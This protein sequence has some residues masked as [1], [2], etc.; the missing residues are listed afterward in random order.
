M[1]RRVAHSVFLFL[2]VIPCSWAVIILKDDPRRA[3]VLLI[4]GCIGLAINGLSLAS[5]A[6]GLRWPLRIIAGGVGLIVLAGVM[7]MWQWIRTQL[8]PETPPAALARREILQSQMINLLWI[9][10]VVVYVLLTIAIQP[11]PPAKKRP[12]KPRR[13]DFRTYGRE[14]S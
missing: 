4:L 14:D 8:L 6:F 10:G 11:I 9:A 2:G 5:P 13:I 3:G 7:A 1:W 12:E